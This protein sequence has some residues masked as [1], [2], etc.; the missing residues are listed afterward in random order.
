MPTYEEHQIITIRQN[1]NRGLGAR[2]KKFDI[3]DI[4]LILVLLSFTIGYYP[5]VEDVILQ[6]YSYNDCIYLPVEEALDIARDL[7]TVKVVEMEEDVDVENV[8]IKFNFTSDEYEL[9]GL[10]CRAVTGFERAIQYIFSIFV[11]ITLCV[12]MCFVRAN[13]YP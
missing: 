3:G 8:Y 1:K 4:L 9:R 7:R 11:Y 6:D 13:L 5:F 2:L 12:I 10:P